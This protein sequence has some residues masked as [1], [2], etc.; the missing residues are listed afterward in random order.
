LEVVELVDVLDLQLEVKALLQ[1][2][3]QL[4]Q[5]VGEDHQEQELHPLLQDQEDQEEVELYHLMHQL[6]EQEIVLQQVHHRVTQ[7]DLINPLHYLVEVV[8]EVQVQLVR[9][10]Q[11][12]LDQEE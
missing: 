9:Q 5:L 4:R 2:F 6:E 12:F 8:E 7:V 10:E 1:F 11:M 3:Q